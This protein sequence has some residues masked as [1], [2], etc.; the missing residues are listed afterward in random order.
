[1]D[2]E[3]TEAPAAPVVETEPL[4]ETPEKVVEAGSIE[5]SIGSASLDDRNDVSQGYLCQ[6]HLCQGYLCQGYLCQGYLCQGYVR[7]DL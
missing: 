2:A 7:H 4:E 3:S 1:M 5:G 6:G